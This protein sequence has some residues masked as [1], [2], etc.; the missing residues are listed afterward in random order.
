MISSIVIFWPLCRGPVKVSAPSD[1]ETVQ[2]F[3][4]ATDM[5]PSVC[6]RYPLGGSGIRTLSRAS[7]VAAAVGCATAAGSRSSSAG[8][9]PGSSTRRRVTSSPSTAA[10]VTTVRST[11]RTSRPDEVPSWRSRSREASRRSR[12]RE[13]S[14]WSRSREAS[15]RSRARAAGPSRCSPSVRPS[16]PPRSAA[17]RETGPVS[18]RG[19]A[20]ARE[21]RAAGGASGAAAC[22]IACGPEEESSSGGTGTRTGPDGVSM[23]RIGFGPDGKSRGGS[24]PAGSASCGVGADSGVAAEYGAP[25]PWL[26]RICSSISW[27]CAAGSRSAGFLRSRPWITGSRAPARC[28]GAGSCVSTA[29]STA[30]ASGPSYGGRPSTAV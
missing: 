14:R 22:G 4:T 26:R 1:S 8:S 25:A 29:P 18:C 15:R 2:F 21:G 11:E 24:S 12:S 3:G 13:A 28:G 9:P 16:P 7:G 17:A 5:P 30:T 10:A 27:T 6:V 19:Q 20:S 23:M